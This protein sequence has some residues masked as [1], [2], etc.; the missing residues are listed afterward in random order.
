MYEK[1][2]R[3]LSG[4]EEF[5]RIALIAVPPYG[6]GNVRENSPC[7][8]GR[9][10]KSKEWFVTTPAVALLADGKVTAA[11]EEKA[12]DFDEILQKFTQK[13]EKQEKSRFLNQ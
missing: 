11:W 4:N 9:L 5:M 1:M 3:D 8:L 7:K 10:D 2:A 12:P 13:E 6:R